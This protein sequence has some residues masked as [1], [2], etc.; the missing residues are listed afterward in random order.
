[1]ESN[2]FRLILF[3]RGVYDPIPS[4][5]SVAGIQ[6]TGHVLKGRSIC[7]VATPV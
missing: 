7:K 5:K 1:M 2:L 6:R 3:R 4:Y